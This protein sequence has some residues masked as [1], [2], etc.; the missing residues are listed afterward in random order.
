MSSS[1]SERNEGGSMTTK[2]RIYLDLWETDTQ[3]LRS[4]NLAINLVVYEK[5]QVEVVR[6]QKIISVRYNRAG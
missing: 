1:L 3:I 6:M 2:E 4:P 5:W